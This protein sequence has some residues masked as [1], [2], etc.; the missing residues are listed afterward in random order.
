[1]R[2][3]R[4]SSS[5]RRAAIL[6]AARRVFAE[7]GYEGAKTQHIAAA[8]G[9][10]DT[11]V[12]KHFGSKR[13]LY[14][15]VLASLV[16][17]Q[18]ASFEKT[19]LP[20]AST[21]SLLEAIWKYLDTCIHS[22]KRDAEGTRILIANLAADGAYARF[23]FKR[24]NRLLDRPMHRVLAAAKASGDLA[25]SSVDPINASLYIAHVGAIISVSRASASP[26]IPYRGDDAALLRDTFRFCVRG[27]GVTDD[28]VQRFERARLLVKPAV[29]DATGARRHARRNRTAVPSRSAP[30]GNS[31]AV[32]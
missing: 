7:R 16:R 1:M 27:L 15:E 8:A 28:A 5:D 23:V 31:G 12:F 25:A 3:T 2:H 4:I 6:L 19:T 26:T 11:L 17:Q 10:S 22:S 20:E 24:A 21:Q 32:G 13:G 9:V 18:D 30:R 14:R 29:A